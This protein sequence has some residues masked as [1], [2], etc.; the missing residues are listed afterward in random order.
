MAALPQ[1]LSQS[2]GSL[3]LAQIVSFG[4]GQD[5]EVAGS[6]AKSSSTYHQVS[7]Y[8]DDSNIVCDS[9]PV[10]GRTEHCT[11]I[12]RTS[13]LIDDGQVISTVFYKYKLRI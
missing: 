13:E 3:T 7:E 1:V 5:P 4:N 12:C 2:H 11:F 10:L 8:D 6:M 9:C